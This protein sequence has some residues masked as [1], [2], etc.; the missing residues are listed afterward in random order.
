MLTTRQEN[1]GGLPFVENQKQ[2]GHFPSNLEDT[3]PLKNQKKLH[4]GFVDNPPGNY[5][6]LPFDENQKQSGHFPFVLEYIF[7]LKNQKELHLGYDDN[8]PRKLRRTAF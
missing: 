6:E 7:P 2:S 4:F 3:F 1:L 8:P 5:G